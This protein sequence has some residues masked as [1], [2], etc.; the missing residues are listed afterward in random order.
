MGAGTACTLAGGLLTSSA[1]S[2]PKS[3]KFYRRPPVIERVLSVYAD[4]TDEVFEARV[5]EWG[6]MVKREFPY[7]VPITEWLILVKQNK[8]GELPIFDNTQ[9]ELRITPRFS[10]KPMKENFDWSIRCPR[11]QFTVNM[12]SD[13]SQGERR[14]YAHVRDEFARWLSM[15]IQHFSVGSLQKVTAHYVN[16]VGRPTMPDFVGRDGQL[17]LGDA[18]TVF[19]NIPGEHECLM[20]PFDCKA[21]VGLQGHDGATLRLAV[22]DW[23]NDRYG[24]AVRVDFVVSVP[25]SGTAS[26]SHILSLLDWC[27]ERIIDRFEVVFTDKAK[28]SFEPVE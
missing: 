7:E 19:T 27:H 3:P 15:W 20:A 22:N 14:R 21:T 23:S 9:P 26:S 11:G 24:P 5:E 13:P 1:L 17:L 6:E 16:L 10:K 18:L 28:Q 4:M 2:M 8:E 12:H 25:A